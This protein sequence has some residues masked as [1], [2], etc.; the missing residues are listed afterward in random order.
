MNGKRK[1]SV[2]ERLERDTDA[3]SELV[4]EVRSLEKLALDRSVHI[5]GNGKWPKWSLER[6][7]LIASLVGVGIN[8]IFSAGIN[9]RTV[10]GDISGMKAAV[11]QLKEAQAELKTKV[12]ELTMTVKTTERANQ[13]YRDQQSTPGPT[14]PQFGRN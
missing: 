14:T 13:L 8:N 6:W 3:D 10:E 1:G 2:S 12:D 11:T 9:W 5:V 7:L 4:G